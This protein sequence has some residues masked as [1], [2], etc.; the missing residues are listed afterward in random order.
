[1]KVHLWAVFFTAGML[2][3]GGEFKTQGEA[4]KKTFTLSEDLRFGADENEDFYIWSSASTCVTVDAKGHI[5]VGDPAAKKVFEFDETGTYLRTIMKPGEGPGELSNLLE[6]KILNDGSALSLERVGGV[7]AR[8]QRLSQKMNHLKTGTGTLILEGP[9]LSP[10]GDSFA[11]FYVVQDQQSGKTHYKTAVFSMDFKPLKVFGDKTG[12]LPDRTK[13][14]DP[15]YWAKRIG[16]NLSRF[17][18]GVY[19]FNYDAHGRLYSASTERYEVTR[20]SR[21]LKKKEQVFKSAY[22]PVANTEAEL[23]A[24]AESL[25]EQIQEDPFLANIVNDAVIRKAVDLSDPPPGKNPICGILPL[26]SGAVLVVREVSHLD[27]QGT[28]DVFAPSGEYV[29]SLQLPDFA[30]VRPVAGLYLPKMT[31]QNG[32]AYTV[33]TDEF[34]DNRVVRY[35]VTWQ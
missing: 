12:P 34:G 9:V 25:A 21:D 10:V 1:M 7:T 16:E 29:G 24:Y 18:D 30:F 6:F 22:K 11:S 15:G 3:G 26:A 20:W 5:I 27:R 8:W 17:Y 33:L 32:Y 2:F 28:A 31:F 35:R 19:V 13:I 23:V 14:T 4:S